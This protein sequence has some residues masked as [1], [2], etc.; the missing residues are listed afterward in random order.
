MPSW[1]PIGAGEVAASDLVEGPRQ[2][3][4]LVG[5][6]VLV[7]HA[8]AG[9]LVQLAV[10]R[11]QQLRGLLL[12]AGVGGLAERAHGG[13]QRGLPRLVAQPG[14]LVGTVALLLRLD[15]GHALVPS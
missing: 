10:R 1:W 5:R 12:V 7:D 2:R 6:L 13:A 4:L 9:R 8:L 11:H 3:G 15:V 14:A